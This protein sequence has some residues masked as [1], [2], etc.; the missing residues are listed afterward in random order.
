[1]TA[2]RIALDGLIA[3]IGGGNMP[4]SLIG[5]LLARGV[6][7]ASIRVAEPVAATRDALTR[8][9]GVQVFND[10]ADAVDGAA[11][12]LLAVKPQVTRAVCEALAPYAQRSRPLV[13]SIAAGITTGQLARWLSAT[14]ASPLAIVRCMPNTPALI[15]ES[16]TGLFANAHVDAAGRK[17]AETLLAAVGRTVWIDHETRMDAVTAVSG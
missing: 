1:M 17:R 16:A 5:G 4:R 14:D 15:G 10:S 2:R 3:F 8:D 7:A 9:F 12:W 6:L 13:M 11:I